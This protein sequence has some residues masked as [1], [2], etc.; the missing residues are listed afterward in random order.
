MYATGVATVVQALST[1]ATYWER[2]GL[3]RWVALNMWSR[4]P[5][6]ETK[7]TI[8]VL[9]AVL[10]PGMRHIAFLNA[11]FFNI[12][13]IEANLYKNL[14]NDI[15]NAIV[16]SKQQEEFTNRATIQNPKS[17]YTEGR[18]ERRGE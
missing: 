4:T 16:T 15:V 13:D 2:I 9:Q 18:E 11:H 1:E 12:E 3:H 10:R 7:Q 8:E 5:A 14:L 17:L 6:A